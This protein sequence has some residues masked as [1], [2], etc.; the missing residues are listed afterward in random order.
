MGRYE[1]YQNLIDAK[2]LQGYKWDQILTQSYDADEHKYY[3]SAS[4][5]E[6]KA[7][8]DANASVV[9]HIQEENAGDVADFYIP[10]DVIYAQTSTTPPN[11]GA[12]FNGVYELEFEAPTPDEKLY[13]NE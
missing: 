3:L 12:Y 5:N 13:F 8:K 2:I 7:M 11:Y 9:L 10:L 1:D 4:Y 6:L